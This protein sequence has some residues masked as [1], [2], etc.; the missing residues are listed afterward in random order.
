MK[1]LAFVFFATIIFSCTPNQNKND[2]FGTWVFENDGS[3]ME[4]IISASTL[5]AIYT[6]NSP[7]SPRRTVFEIF[8]WERISNDD[9]VSRG[10]YP[11]GFL[12]GLRSEQANDTARLFINRAKTSLISAYQY[13]GNY[14]KDFYAKQ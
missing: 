12:L 10:D 14:R 1:K 13:N 3:K 9:I 8:S 11:S 2:F 6:D 5:T 7:W 4:Y